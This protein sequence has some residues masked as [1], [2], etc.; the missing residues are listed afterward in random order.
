MTLGLLFYAALTGLY[1]WAPISMGLR[2]WLFH[3]AP[4]GAPEGPVKFTSSLLLARLH[5]RARPHNCTTSQSDDRTNARTH[6][7]QSAPARTGLTST[8]NSST[9]KV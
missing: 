1:S 3:V 9:I 7:A 5:N 8:L 6:G 4:F 2:P